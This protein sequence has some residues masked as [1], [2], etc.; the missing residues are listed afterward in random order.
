MKKVLVLACLSAGLS[1]AT[2]QVGINTE[3]PKSTFDIKAS[4][5]TGPLAE[6][7]IIPRI[8]KDK[9][10]AMASIEK[11]TMVYITSGN[12]VDS[13]APTA[14]KTVDV[15][16]EGFYFYDGT[17]WTKIGTSNT[18][19]VEEK[20]AYLP[21]IALPVGPNDPL[22]ADISGNYFKTED[23]S[24]NVITYTVKV[25]EIFKNQ[26]EKPVFASDQPGFVFTDL[27]KSTLETVVKNATDYKFYITY[28]DQNIFKNIDITPAGVLTYEIDNTAIIRANSFMNIV[29]KY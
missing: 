7:L 29:V 4:T 6:G 19:P 16:A 1:L 28:A 21:S 11:S 15:N 22:L 20:F 27:N 9:A 3:T 14:V 13:P 23:P 18:A 5:S 12:F 25:Y 24:T 17:K 2:A 10:E 8:T 26:F